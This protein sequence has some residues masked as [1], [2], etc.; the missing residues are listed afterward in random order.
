MTTA[1]PS[2]SN[3]PGVF[4]QPD[5]MGHSGGIAG[6]RSILHYAKDRDTVV[7]VLDNHDGADP[8]ASLA[9]V[10]HPALTFLRTED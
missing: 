8:E 4:L 7:V 6:F 3:G 9:D 5:S 2:S 1:A 10:L